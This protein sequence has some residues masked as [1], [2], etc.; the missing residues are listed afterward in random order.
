[1]GKLSAGL[2]AYLAKKNGQNVATP[3]SASGVPMIPMNQQMM[4]SIKASPKGKLPAGL[5]KYLD[6]KKKGKVTPKK[7]VKATT[8][9][10]TKVA[11]NFQ[12]AEK[13]LGVLQH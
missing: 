2:A 8:K 7:T 13:K 12:A 9:K 10:K 3:T 1:M 6:N 5:Q 11:Y 4:T